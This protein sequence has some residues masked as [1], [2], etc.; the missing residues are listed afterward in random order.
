MIVTSE[1]IGGTVE[2]HYNRP[3]LESGVALLNNTTTGHYVRNVH[4]INVI[5]IEPIL[6]GEMCLSVS[7]RVGRSVDSGEIKFQYSQ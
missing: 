7:L 3:V 2:Q 6:S 5:E 1:E 4:S